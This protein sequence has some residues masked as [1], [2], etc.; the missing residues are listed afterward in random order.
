VVELDAGSDAAITSGQ[1]T[2]TGSGPQYAFDV[3][4]AYAKY[5][6]NGFSLVAG[7][8]VTFEGIEVIEGPNNPTL[9][10]GY[11]FGFAEPFTH[12][13]FKA[14]YAFSDKVDLTVGIVNGWDQWIDNNDWKTIIFRLGLTPSDKFFAGLSGSIGSETA[15]DKNPRISVDFTGAYVSSESFTLNF[16]ANFGTQKDAGVNDMGAVAAGTW[17]GIGLQPVYKDGAFS[18]GSRVE[19]MMDKNGSRMALGPKGQYL[20]ITLDPGYTLAEHFTL[21]LEGRGD[22]VLAANDGPG[23]KKVLNG[24]STQFS[25]GL[26]AHY[27]F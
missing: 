3:Q 13:G 6:K 9:T 22:F 21:R 8:F 23:G 1:T 27:V 10:R 15:D 16:Q 14:G 7:K 4:E 5:S 11:L 20:N 12:I 24:K 19:W 2:Y 25:L 17:F 26:G 18:F